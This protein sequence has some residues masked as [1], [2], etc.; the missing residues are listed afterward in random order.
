MANVFVNPK[1]HP[2]CLELSLFEKWTGAIEVTSLVGLGQRI[3]R[4]F[5]L[6]LFHVL[7]TCVK[8]LPK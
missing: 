3:D 8:Y 4:I 5:I 6:F 1:T 7:R 2:E